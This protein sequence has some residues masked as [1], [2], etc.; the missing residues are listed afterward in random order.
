VIRSPHKL[1]ADLANAAEVADAVGL[2]ETTAVYIPARI[3]KLR[4]VE[5]IEKFAPELKSCRLGNGNSLGYAH[6]EVVDAG[7]MEKATV[8]SS[9]RA[10]RSVQRE[11]ALIK[12]GIAT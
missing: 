5:D 7:T 6:V 2:P 10:E 3:S 11:C 1:Q 4:M 8:G 12:V 9:E